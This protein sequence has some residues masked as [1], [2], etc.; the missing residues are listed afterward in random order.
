MVTALAISSILRPFDNETNDRIEIHIIN[1]IWNGVL[2][3]HDNTGV[4]HPEAY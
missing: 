3:T 1:C 2:S 4:L